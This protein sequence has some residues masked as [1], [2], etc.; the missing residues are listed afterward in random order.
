MRWF[1]ERGSLAGLIG[2]EDAIGYFGRTS[3]MTVKANLDDVADG[4][5]RWATAGVG[6][7]R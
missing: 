5:P 6:G 3:L 1:D 4:L 7:T 2:I